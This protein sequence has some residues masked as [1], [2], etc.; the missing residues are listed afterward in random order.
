LSRNSENVS[1]IHIIII[2]DYCVMMEQIVDELASCMGCF[3]GFLMAKSGEAVVSCAMT[4]HLATSH[5][6]CN[7]FGEEANSS[8]P[9]ATVFS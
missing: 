2:S 5:S 1:K 4:M 8:D 9:P 7:N 3:T 6:Q